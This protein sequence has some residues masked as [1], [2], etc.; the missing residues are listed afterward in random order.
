MK[1]YLSLLFI[2]MWACATA[3]AQ[4]TFTQHVK[5]YTAG[6]GRVRILQDS[7]I[8]RAVNNLP[9]PKPAKKQETGKG[10]DTK[11]NGGEATHPAAAH[12][13][14][15]GEKSHETPHNTTPAKPSSTTSE[16]EGRTTPEPR[17]VA[18]QHQRYKAMGYRIQIYTGSNSHQDNSQAYAIGQKCQQRFPELSAYPK[19]ISPRW[20]C[21]VGD[22]KT[23]AEAAAYVRKIK[24][25][26]IST[27]V[28]II[29]CE[30]L[31]AR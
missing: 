3:Q 12:P 30:V 15:G 18:V 6:E 23:Q 24:A 5:K 7:L 20:V 22:F 19:F 28:N 13:A 31:L 17:P 14:T 21:R 10:S 8:E 29:R 4:G 1:H 16:A 27:E 25:A 26:R 2:M 11:K 9:A